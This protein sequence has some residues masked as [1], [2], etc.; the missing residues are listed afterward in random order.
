[1]G[2]AGGR[3]GVQ[4]PAIIV[5]STTPQAQMS[6]LNPAAT[7]EMARRSIRQGGSSLRFRRHLT[8]VRQPVQH[9]RRDVHLRKDA[10]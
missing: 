4:A 8:I 5:K 6:A 7:K 2:N 1:M 3:R 10:G 9:L